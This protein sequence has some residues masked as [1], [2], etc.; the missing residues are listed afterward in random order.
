MKNRNRFILMLVVLM[1]C[2]G[3]RAADIVVIANSSVK[4]NE[5]SADELR[6]VFTGAKSALKDGSHV[7][8]VMLRA[9]AA[10]EGF[11][12]EVIGKSDSAFRAGWRSLVFTGQGSLPRT[13]D[14]EAA[15][16]EY[17]A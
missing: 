7:V 14:T 5:A 16:V 17:V 15:L 4:A 12:K 10:H 2:G 11:L 13:L 9:G 6:E 1:A 3:L 8:P